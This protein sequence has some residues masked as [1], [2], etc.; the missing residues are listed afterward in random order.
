MS[1]LRVAY[2][3]RSDRLLSGAWDLSNG[4]TMDENVS[5]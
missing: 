3:Q 2:L 4:C 5:P 1:F